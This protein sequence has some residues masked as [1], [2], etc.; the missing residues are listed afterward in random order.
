MDKL[1]WN[2][3][4]GMYHGAPIGHNIRIAKGSHLGSVLTSIEE[5]VSASKGTETFRSRFLKEY[6]YFRIRGNH[7]KTATM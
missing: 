6:T 3:Q 7:E 1:P 2:N 4:L 5:K